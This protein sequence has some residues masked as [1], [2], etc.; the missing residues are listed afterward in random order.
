MTDDPHWAVL[1]AVIAIT[2][3]AMFGAYIAWNLWSTNRDLLRERIFDRR[4]E[5]FKAT[6]SLISRVAKDEGISWHSANELSDI[7]QQARFMFPEKDAQYF[8]L[9]RR[10]ALELAKVTAETDAVRMVGHSVQKEE[11]HR[12]C[13]WFNEQTE[14][15]FS[16][17]SEFLLFE[18]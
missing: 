13:D 18:R 10:N 8:D 16:R 4:F 9:L 3:V 14:E 2:A 7:A 1:I 5:I 12:L 6:Q 17:M 11:R 15:L